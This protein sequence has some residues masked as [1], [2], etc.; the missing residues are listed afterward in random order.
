MRVEHPEE[1]RVHEV[2]GKPIQDTR[3]SEKEQV[4]RC[5]VKKKE[6][7]AMAMALRGVLMIFVAIGDMEL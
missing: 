7:H 6:K 4:V 5:G 1:Y 3:Q 2:G